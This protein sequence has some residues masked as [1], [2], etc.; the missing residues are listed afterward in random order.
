MTRETNEAPDSVTIEIGWKAGMA[1]LVVV[2]LLAGAFFVWPRLQASLPALGGPAGAGGQAAL[3]ATVGERR[4]TEHEVDMMFTIQK[5]MAELAG[6]QLD[7]SAAVVQAVKRDMLD[8][9]VDGALL[10]DAARAAGLSVNDATVDAEITPVLAAQNIKLEIAKPAL[11]AA[12]VSEADFRA[13]AGEQ[14]LISRYTQTPD[15]LAKGRE[16]LLKRGIPANMLDQA[17][18]S[19]ADVA[20]ALQETADIRF[21]LMDEAKGSPPVREGQPAPDFTVSG[22][23]GQPL[24]LSSLRGKP[25][26]VNFW[27]TWCTPCKIEMPI[28]ASTYEQYKAQDVQEPVEQVQDFLAA[29]KLPFRIGLDGDGS[30][31]TIYR[32]RALPTT[33]FIGADGIVSKVHRGAIQTAEE[34]APFLQT[35]LP[36]AQASATI[37]PASK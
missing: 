28:F 10:A 2:L 37:A 22:P 25:V 17:P 7:P 1:F 36:G 16:T 15:A 11:V 31:A 29:N 21:F 30:V 13:W 5:V 8:Q 24:A 27:A 34:L 32:V 23:D 20:S 6:K 4:I 12:G 9:L 19:A 33:V 3:L 18:L 35:I 26:M 14:L